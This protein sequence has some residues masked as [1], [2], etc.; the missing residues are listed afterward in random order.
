[1]STGDS[2]VTAGLSTGPGAEVC[3]IA[4]C[5]QQPDDHNL[6]DVMSDRLAHCGPN[7]TG[8]W[9]HQ[10]DRV[11]AQLGH[12]RLSIIDLSTTADQRTR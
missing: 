4:G 7:A 6:V 3:G 10:D 12:R 5:Y 8:T 11:A 2:S 9:S 1:V